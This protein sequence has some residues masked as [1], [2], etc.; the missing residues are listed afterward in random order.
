MEFF[1]QH[2]RALVVLALALL[3]IIAATYEAVAAPP[4]NFPSGREFVV[5]EGAPLSTIASEL[6]DARIIKNASVLLVIMRVSGVSRR[7]QAGTYLFKSPENAFGVARRI[8]AGDYGI[9]LVRL[10][11]P[12]G[13]TVREIALSTAESISGFSREALIAAGKKHEG[14]LFPDTYFFP[15]S[16]DAE[17]IITAMRKNFDAKIDPLMSEIQG[18]GHS[19][20]DIV[21]MASLL[22]KEVRTTENRRIVAG[23]LWDRLVLGMPLQ[24]D[25]V[26][27]YIFDRD[28]FAPSFE[29][30]KVDSPYNTYRNIG[31]PP[32][33]INNPGLDAIGAALHP[34]KTKYLYYLT[35]KDGNIHYAVTYAEHQ[36]N[37]KKYLR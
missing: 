29:D 6:R 24:V 37:Q 21:I 15:P 4:A 3:I 18:S 12:E 14:Y 13:I 22:E 25:A 16:T 19:L 30:L 17:T 33:P 11:F 27:G 23:I 35:D 8:A 20:S 1:K 34:T 36:L 32:G 31:L 9:S 7:V 2:E 10:T 26:F 5:A 28:T